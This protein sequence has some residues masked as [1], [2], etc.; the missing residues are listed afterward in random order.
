MSGIFDFDD[1]IT[2]HIDSKGGGP[3]AYASTQSLTKLGVLN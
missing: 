1:S 2:E 3:H